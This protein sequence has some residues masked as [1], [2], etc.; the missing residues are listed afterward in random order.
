M[1]K[2]ILLAAPLILM[3]ATCKKTANSPIRFVKDC[4]GSYLRY[5][6]KDYHICNTEKTAA[7]SNGDTVLAAFHKIKVCDDT[8][9]KGIVCMMYHMN[10]GWIKVDEIQHG[11]VQV[12]K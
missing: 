4:T 9:S 12:D 11:W 6:G 3:S 2:A 10:E 1:K 8:A 5:R 7:L